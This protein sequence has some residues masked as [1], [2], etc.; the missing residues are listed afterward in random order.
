MTDQIVA[1]TAIATLSAS[2]QLCI[3]AHATTDVVVD[4]TGWLGQS[5][6]TRFNAVGPTG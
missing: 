4:V 6:G 3:Y 5:T 2:G 1:N